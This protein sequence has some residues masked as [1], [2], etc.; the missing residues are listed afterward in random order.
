MITVYYNAEI[1]DEALVYVKGGE[2]IW[3]DWVDSNPVW[4]ELNP[5][6]PFP[7]GAHFE[8]FVLRD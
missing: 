6:T 3:S 2:F 5:D 7:D 4:E 8:L 1:G